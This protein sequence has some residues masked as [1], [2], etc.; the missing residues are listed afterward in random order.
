MTSPFL[1][2]IF[3]ASTGHITAKDNALLTE[4]DNSTLVI[5][6]YEFGYFIFVDVDI[7]LGQD[8]FTSLE[9]EGYSPELVKLIRRAIQHKCKFL[10]LDCD[11]AE[12]ADLPTF[13]W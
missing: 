7:D 13:I 5:Y 1:A 4:E 10:Q 8:T 2:T 3:E 9:A 12:Y 6:R 11:G